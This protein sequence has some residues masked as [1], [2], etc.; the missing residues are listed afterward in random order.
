ML[1]RLK[2]RAAVRSPSNIYL[3]VHLFPVVKHNTVPPWI[4][5]VRDIHAGMGVHN[6]NNTWL[7]ALL[8]K[9]QATAKI[10]IICSR[11]R[12]RKSN[13][14]QR[15]ISKFIAA[16]VIPRTCGWYLRSLD[17]LQL[18]C[19]VVFWRALLSWISSLGFE[20]PI[21]VHFTSHIAT[22]ERD[23]LT[24]ELR[25]KRTSFRHWPR[26]ASRL[27]RTCSRH[28]TSHPVTVFVLFFPA[29]LLSSSLELDQTAAELALT[30]QSAKS[31]TM[32]QGQRNPE[33]AFAFMTLPSPYAPW[34]GQCVERERKQ[35]RRHLQTSFREKTQYQR[36]GLKPRLRS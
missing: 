32:V 19:K 35:G 28:Q 23:F 16:Q 12:C 8:T 27:Q 34:H 3:S 33:E 4:R 31:A 11:Q 10:Q 24:N 20:Q 5:A 1:V 29:F 15:S 36:Y 17:V 6:F 22:D 9:K 2:K 30:S 21:R 7:N 26:A 14:E 25:D 18:V 13:F